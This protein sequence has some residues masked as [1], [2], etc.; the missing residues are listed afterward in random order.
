MVDVAVNYRTV[1]SRINEA[2]AKAGRDPRSIK[3]L[4]AAK[5]QSV[6]AVR[7]AVAAGV[8]LIG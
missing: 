5:S 3:L 2:A 6:D 7:E 8:T 1:I 4:A